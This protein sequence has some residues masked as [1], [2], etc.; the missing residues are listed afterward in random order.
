MDPNLAYGTFTDDFTTQYYKDLL[1]LDQ[2]QRAFD[3]LQGG[4]FDADM[5]ETI[6]DM[7]GMEGVESY[8]QSR[9]ESALGLDPK[10]QAEEL[11]RELK[12]ILFNT[13]TI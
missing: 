8:R 12:T 9:A 1:A 7:Y 2:A 10:S 13:A 4:F 6:F 11:E 3:R 5:E